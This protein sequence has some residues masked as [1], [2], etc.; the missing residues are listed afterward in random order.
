MGSVLARLFRPDRQDFWIRLQLS[1]EELTHQSALVKCH[2]GEGPILCHLSLNWTL[3]LLLSTR[4]KLADTV[5]E[6]FGKLQGRREAWNF[7]R[8]ACETFL[9]DRNLFLTPDFENNA[10]SELLRIQ[11][12]D[13]N[14]TGQQMLQLYL[15]GS[16]ENYM[17]TL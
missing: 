9:F 4:V 8:A 10:S 11:E 7:Y 12:V 6:N 1:Y 14:E 17:Q 2:F 5:E 15:P 13:S 16:Q 3:Y